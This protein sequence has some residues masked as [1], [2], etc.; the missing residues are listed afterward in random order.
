M[1]VGTHGAVQ[2]RD[3]RSGAGS[4]GA[5][6]RPLQ[7]LPPD[8]ATGRGAWWPSSEAF[9]EFMGWDGPLLTDSGGFQVFS[10]P[11]KKKQ[12]SATD[13]VKSSATR[14]TGQDSRDLTPER[15]IADPGTAWAPT[16]SWPSTSARPTPQ[17]ARARAYRGCAAPSAWARSLPAGAQAPGAG[18]VRESCRAA[19]TPNLRASC[20]ESAGERS[21]CRGTPSAGCRWA[22]GTICCVR[23]PKYTAPLLPEDR[24]RYLMGVGMPED[25]A[26][27]HRLRHRSCSTASFPR[28]MRVAPPPSRPV[29]GSG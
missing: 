27:C 5:A 28:V 16:S 13:G 23:S 24:P 14:W 26:R 29:A 9:T 1:P 22:R 20:A 12:I 2:G 6:D 18:S 11:D 3:A 4:T 21:T 25:R 19:S 10:L 17:R 8:P 7:H 15:S